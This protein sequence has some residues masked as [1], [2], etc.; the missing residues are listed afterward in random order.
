MGTLSINDV[1]RPLGITQWEY[2]WKG[3][4]GGLPST[5]PEAFIGV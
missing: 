4:E 1:T 2:V 3:C 5:R